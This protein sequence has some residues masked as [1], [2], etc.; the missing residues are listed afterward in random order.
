[1]TVN[2]KNRPELLFY[3]QLAE[4]LG[5]SLQ[6]I[7]ALPSTELVGWKEYYQIF[8][9]PQERADA[10][11]AVIAQ[12]IANMSGK[13]LKDGFQLRMDEFL[14]D[15]LGRKN[16]PM[17]EQQLIDA[18]TKFVEKALESGFGKMDG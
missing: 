8:P 3:Y 17:T 7:M 15:Y 14:P 9:F 2:L 18:E 10:R 5:K 11:A 16:Q 12:T 1:M 4:T 6:E 13:T